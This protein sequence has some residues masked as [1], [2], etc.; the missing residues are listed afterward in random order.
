MKRALFCTLLCGLLASA[1]AASVRL[2]IYTGSGTDPM[3]P[4]GWW[5]EQHVVSVA[6]NDWDIGHTVSFTNDGQSGSIYLDQNGFSVSNLTDVGHPSS[7][8]AS[9]D[10][11]I[12]D[13]ASGPYWLR[14]VG[15]TSFV[16]ENRGNGLVLT[17]GIYRL[18]VTR[19]DSNVLGPTATTKYD[20]ARMVPEANTWAMM[21]TGFGLVGG[22]MRMRRSIRIAFA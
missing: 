11:P 19:F 8:E 21:L 9:F 3:N 4:L 20:Y 10:E 16:T 18:V 7:I 12:I 5:E 14:D 15:N 22:V 1:S 2:S 6:L 13:L 17:G